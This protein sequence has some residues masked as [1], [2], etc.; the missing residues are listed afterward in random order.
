MPLFQNSFFKSNNQA[1]EDE[2]AK[3]VSLLKNGDMDGASRHF[4]QAMSGGHTS[5][6][7]NLYLM[8]GAGTVS[9]YDFDAAADCWY[10]AAA[11]HPKAKE[12]LWLIEAADRGGFGTEILADFA[13]KQGSQHGLV[14]AVMVCA[15]RFFDVLCRKYGA[16]ADVIAYELDG[17]SRSDWSF[18]HSFIERTGLNES[19]Y[20]GG[21]DRL[22]DGSAADQ[23]TD[24][25]NQLSVA[26]LKAGF[27]DKTVAMAR[28]SIVGYIILKSPY[29]DNA[30]P[31][32]G[33]DRFFEVEGEADDLTVHPLLEKFQALVEKP[34]AA[35]WFGRVAYGW[36]MGLPVDV[37]FEVN[38][39][40][41][42][43]QMVSILAGVSI[44][45]LADA[46]E[47]GDWDEINKRLHA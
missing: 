3:G 19:F 29:G 7:Y 13:T 9:S 34:K 11:G 30:Q 10:K 8:W 43:A 45:D 47:A 33:T 14:A 23:I 1:I 17:A 37:G 5:A 27:D 21:L 25:L 26:M 16:T 24:G 36:D 4:A 22:L 31:L 18:I 2:Y 6:T 20:E 42:I 41:K 28:C 15:A 12:S 39:A 35:E 46:A 32:L 40:L 38:N 44:T